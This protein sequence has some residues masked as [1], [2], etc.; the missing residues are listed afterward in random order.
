MSVCAVAVG[1]CC[2]SQD[3]RIVRACA[4]YIKLNNTKKASSTVVTRACVVCQN[5][6]TVRTSETGQASKTCDC[7]CVYDAASS[8]ERTNS[9]LT[10][11]IIVLLCFVLCSGRLSALRGGL[12]LVLLDLIS[13]NGCGRDL[14]LG[15]H[16]LR[17]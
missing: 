5:K 9:A 4:K 8:T 15:I 7:M 6:G 17:E 2:H 12:Q 10:R 16:L 11:A 3:E 14:Q 13:Q 1:I